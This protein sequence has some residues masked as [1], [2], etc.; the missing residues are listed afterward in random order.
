MTLLAKDMQDKLW[1]K[2]KEMD[3]CMGKDRSQQAVFLM[4][5]G[6][7]EGQL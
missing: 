3:A 6:K 2:D 5:R 1:S 4:G 7:V